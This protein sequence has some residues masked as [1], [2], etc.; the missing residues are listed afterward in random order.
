MAEEI[1]SFMARIGIVGLLILL[2]CA[3]PALAAPMVLFDEAHG[4]QFHVA[5]EGP[6]DLSG[7]A[8]I[9]RQAGDEVRVATQ[10]LTLEALKGVDVLVVSGAF[11]PFSDAELAAVRT[12]LDN[13][14]NVVVML[15]IAPPMDGLLR[16]LEVD[17]SNGTLH[18]NEHMLAD[19]P[20]DFR[21]VDLAD[22][23]LTRGMSGF[24]VYGAW[25]L[26]PTAPSMV[27]VAKT[28][29][30]AWVDLNRDHR[31]TPGDAVQTFSV[32]VAGM[33]GAGRVAVFA[34]DAIF[35]NR[36]LQEGNR[37]LAV[38]LAGWVSPPFR[39]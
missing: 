8:G 17:F 35:Q 5:G 29:S 33:H 38:N 20:L 14:G 31:L 39:P 27:S 22:H 25:A 4:Q 28:G 13:G 15:H 12:F 18:D 21:I 34:D 36:F 1:A 19:N 26:R 6:L 23:P 16:L 24:A 32:I 2:C 10:P 9:F 7:L 3:S 37:Q 11:A 30:H